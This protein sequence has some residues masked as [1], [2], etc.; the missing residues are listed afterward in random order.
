VEWS[1]RLLDGSEQRAFR[2]LSLFPV[3]FT[4]DAALAAAGADAGPAT[5]R[6]VD[7]SLLTPPRAG[8]DG[9]ARYA[10]LETLRSFGRDRLRAAGEEPETAGALAGHA[11][12]IGEAAGAAMEFS[13]GEG[14]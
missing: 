1:Y 5:A 4:L 13:G 6:L 12:A 2:R 7:C 11:L 9:R 14:I 10:M 3:P 8:P